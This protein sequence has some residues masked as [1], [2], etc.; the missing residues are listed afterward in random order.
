MKPQLAAVL[1]AL[2][3][4]APLSAA[5]L[6]QPGQQPQPNQQPPQQPAQDPL[7]DLPHDPIFKT[8]AEGRVIQLTRPAH[9][10]ALEV[11]P[12]IDAETLEACLPII[13]ER[14]E[15]TQRLVLDNLD[16][17]AMA[18]SGAIEEVSVA[19]RP[20]VARIVELLR[21]FVPEENLASELAA[22]GVLTN[23]QARFNA[24]IV[25]DYK[26]PLR[27][28]FIQNAKNPDGTKPNEMDALTR[29]FLYDGIEEVTIAYEN[30]LLN[31][32]E[33]A[34]HAIK[35]A[36][37]EGEAADAIRNAAKTDPDR[38]TVIELMH[39][40]LQKVPFR[41]RRPILAAAAEAP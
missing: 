4:A 2:P 9:E 20:S 35:A 7:P 14:R 19:D 37:L 34:E 16:L 11:N 25:N 15:R 6:L 8:D 23:L 27:R 31:L 18:R 5:Q 28:Q 30:F 40:A 29:F 13:I 26:L 17:I 3:L 24:K 12:T 22:R 39:D 41:Q 33:N 32:H 1:I 10:A 38:A 21:P 36:E